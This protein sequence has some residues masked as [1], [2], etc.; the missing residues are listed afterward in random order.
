MSDTSFLEGE[1]KVDDILAE[2]SERVASLIQKR[3]DIDFAEEKLKEMN[4]QEKELS[5]ESIPQLLFSCGLSSISLTTGEKIEVIEKLTASIPKRNEEN[6][7]KVLKWLIENGGANLIKQELKIEEPEKLIVD[8][9]QKQGIPFSNL[10]SVNANSFKAFLNAK[11][12]LKKGSLQEIELG[13]IPK[14]ANPYVYKETK[15]KE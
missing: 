2:L 9:L 14:E 10:P 13:D 3:K 6:K 7:G 12:G 11:L 4:V 5:Q 8:F 15:I 1:Q